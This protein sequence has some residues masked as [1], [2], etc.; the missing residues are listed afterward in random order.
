MLLLTIFQNP[1]VGLIFVGIL[2]LSITFHEFAHALVANI[3][4][5]P[6]PKLEGRLT[7]N[8]L[9]HLD[10]L[11]SIM[12]LIIGF[13][14]G[15]PV[16]INPS[17]FKRKTD[18]I[19]VS[20]AGIITNLILATI[21]SLLLRFLLG[22]NFVTADSA[23]FQI[24]SLAADVNIAL[25]AFNILPIPPLDGSHIVEHLL[26]P[27][28]SEQ[29]NRIGPLILF[30]IIIYDQLTGATLLNRII[31]P[32]INAFSYIIRGGPSSLI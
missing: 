15:K 4:G 18:D 13:G 12:L 23:T 9:K 1:F 30:A 6:T 22:H 28:T 27:A 8:P 14:W 29:Y 11:G 20:L 19:W 17:Y 26:S 5:D 32:L 16:P 31:S 21:L 7:L 25:A 2:I 3:C 24:L 10:L